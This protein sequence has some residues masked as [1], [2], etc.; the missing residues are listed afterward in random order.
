MIRQEEIVGLAGIHGYSGGC[1]VMEEE[2][3]AM[4]L[5]FQET[6]RE[7]AKAY[8]DLVSLYDLSTVMGIERSVDK[9]CAQIAQRVLQALQVTSVSITLVDP[10]TGKLSLKAAVLGPQEIDE[11]IISEVIKG[12]KAI[13]VNDVRSHPGFQGAGL[14]HP[15]KSVLCAPLGS[16]GKIIGTINVADKL[17]GEDFLAG[18]LKLLSVIAS[19]AGAS[20]QNIQFVQDLELVMLSVVQTLAA[21]VDAKSPWTAEES[22]RASEYAVAIAQGL[23]LN[24]DF[25]YR[26]KLAALLHDIGKIGIGEAILD[27][28]TILTDEEREIVKRHPVKGAELMSHMSRLGEDIVAGIRYHHERYDG[29]GYPDGLSGRE[30]P[31]V[32][33]ILAVADAF[34]AM[35]ADRPYREALSEE[36][37]LGEIESNAGTQFDPKVVEAFIRAYATGKIQR[38]RIPE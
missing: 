35:T 13:I 25:I 36:E 28:P 22:A 33:R 12:G 27:K 31:L 26:L 10:G 4:E 38:M 1:T 17:S 30:I 15:V 9:T 2:P 20:I 8:E 18:D 7:L 37:A 23:A 19:L 21:V 24:P 34:V 3:G 16:R 32:A 6:V 11:G 5:E 14:L 29:R